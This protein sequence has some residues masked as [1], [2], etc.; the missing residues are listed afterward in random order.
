MKRAEYI[1]CIINNFTNSEYPKISYC[2]RDLH[3]EFHFIDIDHAIGNAL[4]EGR[5]IACPDCWKEIKQIME[6]HNDN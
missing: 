1:K 5:L 3:F 6:N 4:I 2:K